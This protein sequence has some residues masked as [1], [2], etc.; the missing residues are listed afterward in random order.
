M[1]ESTISLG[2][3]KA[4]N[5]AAG[6]SVTHPSGPAILTR[7]MFP[8]YDMPIFSHKDHEGQND[9][10]LKLYNFK[11]HLMCNDVTV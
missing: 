5:E 6:M 1:Q 4:E 8:P 3:V 9:C 2:N 10:Q 7:H 11:E